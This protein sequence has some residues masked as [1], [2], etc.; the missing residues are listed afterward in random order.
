MQLN[1]KGK[2]SHRL[3]RYNELTGAVINDQ[4]RQKMADSEIKKNVSLDCGWGKLIFGQT[5]DDH[6]ALVNQLIDERKSGRDIA[7]YIRDHHVL[8]SKAPELLFVDPSDTYRFW[9]HLYRPPKRRSRA[10]TV[11]LLQDRRDAEAINRIYRKCGMFEAPEDTILENQRT[12]IFCYY[13]AERVSDGEVIGTIS[14]IDHKLAFNDPTNGSSF[15]CLSVDPDAQAKGVGRTLVREVAEHF[16]ARGRDYLDLSVMHDN[17]RA[18]ILYH[19]M[20]F[21]Q[22]PV[23]AVKRKN[24]VNRELYLGGPKP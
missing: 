6:D 17:R 23:Y 10:F 13:L 14:G 1:S 2:S 9:L 20:G 8:I 3:E 21:R 18:K 22:V 7:I 5:F 19:K 16:I 15:W 11:R 24:E 12:R 4:N